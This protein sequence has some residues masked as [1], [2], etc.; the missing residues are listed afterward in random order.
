[1]PSVGLPIGH[2][3]LRI[4]LS[5]C[6]SVT[7][8]YVSVCRPADRSQLTLICLSRLRPIRPQ[9]HRHTS[10]GLP[11]GHGRRLCLPSTVPRS[12]SRRRIFPTP[13]GRQ[14]AVASAADYLR[15]AV[16]SAALPD[17]DDRRQLSGCV[18]RRLCLSRRPAGGS[19]PCL[20][21]RRSFCGRCQAAQPTPP[22]GR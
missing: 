19:S 13:A 2:S 22:R 17:A 5:V 9:P 11:I 8:H 20:N 10:A 15:N 1:L 6:R 18:C 12:P 3:P 4:R 14:P 16:S 7:A 21:A